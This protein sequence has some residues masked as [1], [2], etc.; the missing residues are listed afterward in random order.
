MPT[1]IDPT[2]D[3]GSSAA[4]PQIKIYRG[5]PQAQSGEGKPFPDFVVLDRRPGSTAPRRL[6]TSASQLYRL[7]DP[8]NYKKS[9]DQMLALLLVLGCDVDVRAR[10]RKRTA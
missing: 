6:G 2:E 8:T 1:F 10:P 9:V 4:S 5:V 7:L 3:S